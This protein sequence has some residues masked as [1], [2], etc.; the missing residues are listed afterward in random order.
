MLHPI[1]DTGKRAEDVG[2]LDGPVRGGDAFIPPLGAEVAGGADGGN[3]QKAER[4]K[5]AGS[6]GKG[7]FGEESFRWTGS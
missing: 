2:L 1:D 5:G 7:W 6:H 4:N 3:K